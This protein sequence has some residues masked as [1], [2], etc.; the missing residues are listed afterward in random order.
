MKDQLDS[1][2]SKRWKFWLQYSQF[3]CQ[4]GGIPDDSEDVL[5]EVILALL[6]KNKREYLST[7]QTKKTDN[8][9]TELDAL[10]LKMIH[11]NAVSDTAPYRAKYKP[12]NKDKNTDVLLLELEDE[13]DDLCGAGDSTQITLERIRLVREVFESLD[14]TEKAKQIF[15]YR[16]FEDEKFSEWEGPESIQELYNIY[17]D[18]ENI[19][20]KTINGELLF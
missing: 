18:V 3:R 1:Y 4:Q 16:F 2:I 20:R 5:Q 15:S 13:S 10:V 12:A 9:T 6:S 17:N 7:L 19:I 11:L 14:I 8:G